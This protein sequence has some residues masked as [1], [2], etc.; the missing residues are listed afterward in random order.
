MKKIFTAFGMV[1]LLL[2]AQAAFGQADAQPAKRKAVAKNTKAVSAP[3]TTE[4][5]T[6]VA[7]KTLATESATA[8][9]ATPA[10]P[11][12][13]VLEPEKLTTLE[14][15]HD[16]YD[17]GKIVQGDVVKHKFVIK[18]TGKNDLILENVKPSCGCTA[19]DWPKE[20]IAPGKTAT[21]EA[22]FNSAGKMG[23]QVKNI[24]ITYNGEERIKYLSFT[25]EIVPKEGE[26]P[27]DSHE[28]H[29]H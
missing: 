12:A 19:L 7:T 3:K 20:P 10:D 2:T 21:I 5:A 16:T 24:T 23:P 17:F 4:S 11:N 28:G 9:P 15:E 29:Q 8:T 1:T 14:A 25:G 22:Q 18:N 27:A 6:P 26:A 13:P